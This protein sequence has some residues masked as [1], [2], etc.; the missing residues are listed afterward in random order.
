MN[1][2]EIRELLKARNMTQAQLAE[3]LHMHPMSLSKILSGRAPL[4]ETLASHINLLLS[5]KKE[6]LLVF[7]VSLPDAVVEQ[8]IPGFEFLT[9]EERKTAVEAVLHAAAKQCVALG[10]ALYSPE[11]LEALRNFASTL[12][13]RRPELVECCPH[14]VFVQQ[15]Q[16]GEKAEQE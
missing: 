7:R 11:E 4:T 10:E 6:Q 13:C 15:S 9:L 14:T 2:Q 3:M 1:I 12:T 8:W 5:D 16:D